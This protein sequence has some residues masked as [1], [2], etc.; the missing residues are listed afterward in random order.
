VATLFLFWPVQNSEFINL[1]D[2]IYVYDNPQVKAGLSLNG[3]IWAFTTMHMGNW[4]PLTWLS[5]MLDCELYGLNPGPHHVTS[6]LFHIANTLLLFWVLR[7]MTGRLWPSSFV[8]ALFALH[9]LHVESVAW[10][11]ERKDVLSTFFWMLT[12]WA[13]LHYVEEPGFTRYLLAILFFALGLLSKPMLVTLPFVLLLLDYWPL[14]RFSFGQGG[15]Y[16][17]N[18]NP[19]PSR[20]QG[21]FPLH[22]VLEKVPFFSL[23]AVSSVITFVAQ[24]SAEAVQNLEWFSLEA[25]IGNALVSYIVYI[26]KMIWPHPLA[27][28][29]PLPDIL[30][31][32]PAAGAGLLLVCGSILVVRASRKYPYLLVGWLWYLGTLV[33]VIGLVQVGEQALADRYTYVPLIGLFI[34]I[35]WGLADI[36]AGWRYRKTTLV[37]SAV[38]LLSV[39]MVITSLQ[40]K[41]WRNA[42]AL[43]THTLKVTTGNYLIYNNLGVALDNL[44]KTQEAIAYYTEA[45]RINPQ[46]AHAHYNLGSALTSLG[47]NQEALAHYTEALRIKPNYAAAHNNLGVILADLGKTQEAIAHYTEALRIDPHH[48][49]AHYNLGNALARQGKTS[50]A[51][52]HYTEALRNKPADAEA[53]NNLGIAL[54]R[55]GK[56][57]EA[58]SRYAEALRINP[59]YVEG[60]NNLGIALAR[61]GR[62]E[63]ALSHF[64]EALRINPNYADA[65]CNLGNILSLQGKNQEAIAHFIQA[66][67]INPD[68]AEAHFSLGMCYLRVGNQ[69]AAMEEYRILKRINS[70]MANG[71]AKKIFK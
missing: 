62:N 11:A 71:F 68:L 31:M 18:P 30:L 66:L 36:L 35:A 13:Y 41:K 15:V 45:L 52:A 33:P 64:V 22:L 57:Q 44:G 53:Q 63:E 43:F 59:K 8:A 48:A 14:G 56:V 24:R 1:D 2:D 47:K 27:V 12:L 42:V 9:P 55:Q 54:S 6:L 21:S 3:V 10:V 61:Q 16:S 69:S 37:I 46:H 26:G 32:W 40:I 58:I 23:A 4:H 17:S 19:S 25:R 51:I 70:E 29:Y 50:E 49:D 65:H 38:L 34:M 39:F 28:L 7:R 67:R 5:H 60:H 20:H